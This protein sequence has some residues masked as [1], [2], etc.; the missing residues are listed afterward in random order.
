MKKITA[1]ALG[2]LCLGLSAG[3]AA[4]NTAPTTAPN[5][6]DASKVLTVDNP[7]VWCANPTPLNK[8]EGELGRVIHVEANK[9]IDKVTVKSGKG[10]ALV[11]KYFDAEVGNWGFIEL[12]KDVSNYV[13]WVCLP[14]VK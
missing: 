12:D 4:A 9:P 5:Q 10:A 13:I 14:P 6:G 3:P 7:N 2:A 11:S 1:A 8:V